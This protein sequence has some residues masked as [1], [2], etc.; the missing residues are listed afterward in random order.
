MFKV[1]ML[2]SGKMAIIAD[3]G[4]EGLL[5]NVALMVGTSEISGQRELPKPKEKT[6]QDVR[7]AVAGA[8]SVTLTASPRMKSMM[9]ERTTAGVPS[10]ADEIRQEIRGLISELS[11]RDGLKY[12]LA[13]N[14]AYRL[15]HS[16]TGFDVRS[17]RPAKVSGHISLVGTVLKYGKGADMVRCLREYLDR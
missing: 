7:T 3:K 8:S 12:G 2:K 6:L 4:F 13:W 16:K 10:N 15:L 14:K 1:E 9:I 17:V 11:S 5:M